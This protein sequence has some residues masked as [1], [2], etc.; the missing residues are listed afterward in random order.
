[1]KNYT[2]LRRRAVNLFTAGLNASEVFSLPAFR[3]TLCSKTVD[4]WYEL[5][6]YFGGHIPKVKVCKKEKFDPD[7]STFVLNLL[8]ADPS[9]YLREI[10]NALLD[11]GFRK[12]PLSSIYRHLKRKNPSLV[13]LSYRAS[14]ASKATAVEYWQWMVDIKAQSRQML[15]IHIIFFQDKDGFTFDELYN[16]VKSSTQQ[17]HPKIP[18]S[19]MFQ[20]LANVVQ[21][22]VDIVLHM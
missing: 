8:E 18:P 6:E 21:E 4:R 16:C 3:N 7:A 11:A 20:Q 1:M 12:I 14:Q 10:Q 19:F 5:F 22:K 13:N 9:L 2:F 17:E 15:F